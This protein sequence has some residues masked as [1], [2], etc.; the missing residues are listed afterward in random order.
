MLKVNVLNIIVPSLLIQI[1]FYP[2]YTHP[3]FQK[4]NVTECPQTNEDILCL[5]AFLCRQFSQ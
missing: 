3:L 4:E 5:H 1:H 2:P